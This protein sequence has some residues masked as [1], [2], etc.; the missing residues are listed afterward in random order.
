MRKHRLSRSP[1]LLCRPAAHLG[2]VALASALLL[3][4][5]VEWQPL[6]NGCAYREMRKNDY[7][8]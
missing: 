1:Q 2:N 6:A 3:L 4:R 8:Y 7:T 5:K